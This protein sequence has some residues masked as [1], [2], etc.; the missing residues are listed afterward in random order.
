MFRNQGN[1]YQGRS[2]RRNSNK[3]KSKHSFAGLSRAAWLGTFAFIILVGLLLAIPVIDKVLAANPNAGTLT[4][5]G[6]N[7]TWNGL[8]LDYVNPVNASEA[9]CQD[10]T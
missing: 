5:S 2:K 8:A 4:P 10:G 7:V 6:P 9:N 3:S 1:K